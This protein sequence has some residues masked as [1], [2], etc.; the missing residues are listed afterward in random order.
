MNHHANDL[1]V[2]APLSGEIIA[3]EQVSDPVFSG[4]VLGDGIA[5]IPEDGKIYS[6]VN[7]TVTTVSSTLHAYGFSTEIGLDILVHVGLETVSLKGEGFK[8]YIKEGDMVKAGELIAEVDLE[9]LKQKNISATTPVLICT[10]AE[11][12]LMETASGTAVAGKTSV[13][14]LSEKAVEKVPETAAQETKKEKKKLGINFDFLQKLGKV[15]MTVIAVMPAAGL[16]LSVG[17]LVQMAGADVSILMTIGSTMENIGWAIITNL[18]I[19]FAAAIGGSW[20]KERAGGAFAAIISFILINRITGAVFNVTTDMLST[21][22]AVVYSFFGQEML[23]ENYFT[24]ILGSRALNMG[25]F[26]GIIAG[27]VGGIVYNKFYNFRKLPDALSFFNGK[28]FVPLAVIAYSVVVSLV[29]AVIWPVVQ[30]GIN[31]F[32]VWI[33]NSS[34]T[35]PVF[36]PFIYGTLERLLL[37]FGLH[38][39]LTIP[40]NYTSFGGTYTIMTGLNAGSQVFGQDPLWLAWVT[41]LINFKDMGDM[42]AYETLLTTVTPARFKVG[43]MIGATGLLL[44]FALA[45]YK[46]VDADKRKN[47]RSMFISTVLAVFLTGVTEPLEFIFMF[48]ALPLYVVYALLQGCAFAMAGIIDLRLHSFGNLEFITRVPMSLKAG[49]GGDIIN[50][51]I[52]CVAFLIIGYAVAYFMI[53][54]F[55]YATPGRLGNYTDENTDEEAGSAARTTG[56]NSQP[57]RI[58]ALLGGRENI[59]LVDACMTR[60]R[61]TVKDAS[62]VAGEA[63]WKAEGALGLVMKDTGIQ[64]IYGPKADVLKSDINDIL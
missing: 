60:L 7:G 5:I 64:A 39:M 25:V 45:M 40:M 23:V 11:N 4:K 17:K 37:P 44:G 57:E 51:I 14:T 31:A 26:V 53:G 47:Y 49:L 27:F 52:C 34:S 12:K 13:I 15:L 61:V 54:K 62:K 9:Y 3:L 46:R 58:I 1:S 42:A 48:C 59:T 8:V 41:D 19:L 50:F 35:S 22:G 28:R 33:A 32:G 10:G 6:P 30:A 21:P 16:M 56:G 55:K 29:M 63:E 20:A 38:H 2:L 18:H 36:A 24:N 43:Q